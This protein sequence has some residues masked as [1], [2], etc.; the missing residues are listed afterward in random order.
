[1]TAANVR[2]FMVS[3]F[4]ADYLSYEQYAAVFK[5]SSAG[6]ADYG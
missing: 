3:L 4:F 1:M 5:L 6:A 2:I